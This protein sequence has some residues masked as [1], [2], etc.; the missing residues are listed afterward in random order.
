[1]APDLKVEELESEL[2]SLRGLLAARGIELRD[3]RTP[4]RDARD[5][6]D[7]GYSPSDTADRTM[8]SMSLFMAQ[9][10]RHRLLN[11][12]EEAELARRIERGDL[13][14]KERLVNCNLRLV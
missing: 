6:A 2:E 4:D 10:R 5:L 7:A 11:R 12:A 13:E 1:M 3:E 9:V 8:D 14:A